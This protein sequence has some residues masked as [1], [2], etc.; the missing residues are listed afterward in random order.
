MIPR[1]IVP[2]APNRAEGRFGRRAFLGGGA[3]LLSG[4]AVGS[5]VLMSRSPPQARAIFRGEA[6]SEAVFASFS[7]RGWTREALYQK[8]FGRAVQCQLCPNLCLLE[9]S[10][11]GHC[12]NRVNRA[13]RLYTL[14]YGNAAAFH[15]DPI[16]KKPL[17]HFLPQT[18][19]FSLG[20]PGC[21]FRCKN[22]QNWELSQRSPEQLKKTDGAA[23]SLDVQRFNR[24]LRG[25]AA[26]ATLLPED[27]CELALGVGARSIAYTYSEPVTSYEYVLDTA[28]VARKNGLKN[29][30]VS[31]GFINQAPLLE[32]LQVCDAANINLKAITDDLYQS[33]NGGA[34]GPVLATLRTIKEQG[35]WLEVTHLIV[36]GYTDQPEHWKRLAG[37]VVAE[38]GEN[39]P[40]HVSRFVPK[41]QLEHLPP[42]PRSA[43]VEAA[44]I[45]RA[46]GL[47]HVYLGN[48]AEVE[49]ATDTRCPKC[50]KVVVERRGH[51]ATRLELSGSRCTCGAQIAGV[52]SA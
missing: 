28:R 25:D 2:P 39:V 44:R 12:R 11:R 50:G 14:S 23:L 45:A 17:F 21:N 36:P 29:L 1:P 26:R 15:L 20:F 42:T 4:V 40:L 48:A 8:S 47:Q 7:A 38:L 24:R 13:G 51:E 16:E 3:A 22:C 27:V 30:L 5:Y 37:W 31:N 19:A 43:L 46:E 49:G 33:L 35:V 18:H 34:L 52:W 32:L 6:P 41:Y 10:D 9:P